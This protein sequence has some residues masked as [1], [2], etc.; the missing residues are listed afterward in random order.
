MISRISK[1]FELTGRAFT[2]LQRNN[3]L[4]I[5][6]ATAFFTVFSLPPIIILLGNIL[7][8]IIFR[9]EVITEKIYDQLDSIFGEATTNT[10]IQIVENF[11]SMASNRWITAGGILFLIFVSTTLFNV[12]QQAIHRMWRIRTT[13]SNNF[14]Y[15]LRHR[16]ISLLIIILAGILVL[17]T[18]ISETVIAV[19]KDYLSEFLPDTIELLSKPASII[20]SL[21]VYSLWFAG[22]FRYLP[23]ARMPVKYTLQG[24]LFTAVLFSLG[25]L[26]LTTFLIT[27]RFGA[28]FGASASILLLMLFIFYSSM[29]VYFGAAFTFV[30]LKNSGKELPVR[31]H[32]ERYKITSGG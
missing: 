27:D 19:M 28:I 5:S 2:L 21:I 20:I 15:R 32:S 16:G 13:S 11:Q 26:I 3:P 24:G 12:I 22:L 7:S 6:G 10:V 14:M 18:A 9:T 23:G 4:L 25:K 17:V 31:K 8:K 29:L 1:F 30:L